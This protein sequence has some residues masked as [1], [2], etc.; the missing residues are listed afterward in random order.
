MLCQELIAFLIIISA[1][2][3]LACSQ[4]FEAIRDDIHVH[5]GEGQGS[6]LLCRGTLFNPCNVLDCRMRIKT[7]DDWQHVLIKLLSQ[8]DVNVNCNQVASWMIRLESHQWQV[9]ELS[10]DLYCVTTSF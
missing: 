3:N 8:R 5:E 10:A 1:D 6:M 7:D 4:E 9:Q 2:I